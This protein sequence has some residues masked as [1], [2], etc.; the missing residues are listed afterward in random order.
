MWKLS[1]ATIV[2]FGMVGCG[3]IAGDTSNSYETME[4]TYVFIDNGVEY[5]SGTVLHCDDSN[6]SV[7]GSVVGKGSDEEG[8]AVVGEYDDSYTQAECNAAGFFYCTLEDKC[9]NQRVDDAS[10][11]CK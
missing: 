5:G 1:L 3:D 6:C 8:D 10:S 9:L 2:A 11:S 4:Y 7:D